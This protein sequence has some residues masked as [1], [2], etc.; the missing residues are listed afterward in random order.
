MRERR[1]EMQNDVQSRN[2][3]GRT[4]R[5]REAH[6]LEHAEAD[7]EDDIGFDLLQMRI[8]MSHG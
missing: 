3:G 5:L 4:E 7:I 6:D 2:R 8:E 1:R